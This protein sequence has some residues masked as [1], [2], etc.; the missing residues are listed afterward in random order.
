M[1]IKEYRNS[2]MQCIFATPYLN[3]FMLSEYKKMKI[4]RSQ[5]LAPA[6]YD[7]IKQVK[8]GSASIVEP[9]DLKY[10]V[11]RVSAQFSGYG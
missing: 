1:L 2:I 4:S 6:Y 11:S 5:K 9:S 10:A 7:L 8:S 3:D